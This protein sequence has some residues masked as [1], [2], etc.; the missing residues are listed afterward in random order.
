VA[1]LAIILALAY[2]LGALPTGIWIGR[3]L[4]TP[5]VRLH[6]S[7]S[8]GAT[9]VLRAQGWRAALVVALL[10]AAKG[11]IAAGLLPRAAVAELPGASWVP[12]A[13]GLA[14][15]VGH[16]W[17]VWAGLHGG[18]GIA[19]AGGALL[20]INPSVF[21]VVLLLF[22]LLVAISRRVSVASLTSVAAVPLLLYLRAPGDVT[23]PLTFGLILLALVAFTH[24]SNIAKLL[25][26]NEP[27]IGR[28]S[29]G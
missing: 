12:M 4:G 18:K 11:W 14:A 23:A 24:R 2:L 1:K 3:L 19:T 13:A 22:I 17:P 6:G 27:R 15:V 9:N 10:D 26:G 7:G 28:P 20:A 29:A 8:M 21:A 5:D 16:V 25:A